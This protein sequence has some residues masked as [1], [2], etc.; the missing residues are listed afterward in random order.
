MVNVTRCSNN[1]TTYFS[2]SCKNNTTALPKK[3]LNYKFILLV[4]VRNILKYSQ[5]VQWYSTSNISTLDNFLI[6]NVC[7]A[8]R[9]CDWTATG[10]GECPQS[11]WAVQPPSRT[12]TSRTTSSVSIYTLT[13]Q[14]L[15]SIYT[16]STQYLLSSIYR[17]Y[18]ALTT[19][20]LTGHAAPPSQLE[21][22]LTFHSMMLISSLE[23]R[24]YKLVFR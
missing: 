4:P 17:I 13:T 22:G 24:L 12:S 7:N 18:S 8:H 2:W 23:S 6:S 10:C 5:L 16:I 21:L 20:P 15:H 3:Y 1:W 9:S 11:P 19:L 14:Y